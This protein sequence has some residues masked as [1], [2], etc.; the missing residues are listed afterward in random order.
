M[1]VVIRYRLLEEALN[2]DS[3]SDSKAEFLSFMNWWSHYTKNRGGWFWKTFD[4]LEHEL[5][6]RRDR[7]SRYRK[8]YIEMG[9]LSEEKHF[10]RGGMKIFYRVNRKM[11]RQ[12]L[13]KH[14]KAQEGKPI[15]DEVR[16][17]TNQVLRAL[18]LKPLG[19]EYRVTQEC[20]DDPSY[21]LPEADLDPELAY[22]ED[23]IVEP[24]GDCHQSTH[25]DVGD[26]QSLQVEPESD[27]GFGEGNRGF[28]QHPLSEPESSPYIENYKKNKQTTEEESAADSVDEDLADAM[29]DSPRPQVWYVSPTSRFE[30]RFRKQHLPASAFAEFRQANGLTSD[31]ELEHFYTWLINAGRATSHSHSYNLLKK[32]L[33][34]DGQLA[35]ALVA[36]YRQAQASG[37]KPEMSEEELR[38]AQVAEVVNRFKARMEGKTDGQ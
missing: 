22:A 15:Y 14:L 27:S 32:S 33:T 21:L 3:C 36:D 37:F 11:L 2:F 8:M 5:G 23:V 26:D 9:L 10:H 18:F 28:Q 30:S 24:K 34:G 38:Q 25:G 1:R 6:M 31:E 29:I 17:E 19:K 16:A 20:L 4:Q 13:L 35:K 12:I 7:C